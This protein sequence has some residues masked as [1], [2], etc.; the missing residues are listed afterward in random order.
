MIVPRTWSGRAA[1]RGV[2]TEQAGGRS[3]T[4][5]GIDPGGNYAMVICI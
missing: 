1:E 5:V 2:R 4:T 3:K